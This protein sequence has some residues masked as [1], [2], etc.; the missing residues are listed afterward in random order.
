MSLYKSSANI[1]FYFKVTDLWDRVQQHT[2]MVAKTLPDPD[3][4]YVT[5]DDLTFFHRE[6]AKAITVAYE[7]CHKLTTGLTIG[8]IYNSELAIPVT[9]TTTDVEVDLRLPVAATSV[10]YCYAFYV[11]N[12]SGHYDHSLN[13]IN[14]HIETLLVDF[15]Q[16]AWWLKCGVAEQYKAA[17]NDIAIHITMLNNSMYSL[18]KPVITIS[19]SWSTADVTV[20]IEEDGTITETDNTTETLTTPDPTLE[21]LYFD[22][23]AD[24]PTT[25]TADIIY[26]DRSNNNMYDWNGTDYELYGGVAGEY[27]INYVNENSKVVIHNLGKMAPYV[28]GTDSD[29]NTFEPDYEPIDVNSG[30]ASWTTIGSGI[31]RFS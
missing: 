7:L 30:T 29:G 23:R 24:F 21:V 17:S 22:T 15:F 25:G 4:F 14:S 31:L 10:G 11:K 8:V 5:A 12:F 9:D 18:Y 1:L 13:I 6:M 27:E 20:I 26:V 16:Q 19:P 3:K 2:G 28:L